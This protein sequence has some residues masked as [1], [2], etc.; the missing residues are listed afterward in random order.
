[1]IRRPNWLTLPLMI[2]AVLLLFSACH[3]RVEP[4]SS[5]PPSVTL[6]RVLVLPFM[7]MYSVYGDN[8]TYTCPLCGHTSITGEV[9]E[10]ADAYLTRRLHGAMGARDQFELIPPGQAKG[11]QSTLLLPDQ[12]QPS[13]LELVL[14]T[15]RQLSA[16]AVLMGRV[17]RFQERRGNDY[18]ADSPAS[19]SFDILLIYV[20]D[21]RILWRGSFEEAQQPLSDNLYTI[22]NFF[23]RKARWLTAEE[24]ADDGLQEVMATFPRPR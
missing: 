22:D 24:L 15:G 9:A 18:S 1:M 7:D 5:L 6:N 8:V 16:D 2:A 11:V 10:G 3:S 21:G 19:V 17:Y 4:P 20:E 14:E 13:E 23:K 12:G